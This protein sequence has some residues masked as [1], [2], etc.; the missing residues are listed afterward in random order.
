MFLESLSTISGCF[1]C[2]LVF[3]GPAPIKSGSNI[4]LFYLSVRMLPLSPCISLMGF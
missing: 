4:E 2:G 1:S 3:L